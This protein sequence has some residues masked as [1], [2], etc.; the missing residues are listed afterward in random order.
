MATCEDSTTRQIP[1][2]NKYGETVA[3][4]IVDADDYDWLMQ[5]RWSLSACGY[6]SG[7]VRLD[8]KSIVTFMHRYMLRPV[9]GLN[10][11]H[12]NGNRLDNRRCNLRLCTNAENKRNRGSLKNSSSRFVGVSW[13][14]VRRKWTATVHVKLKQ[15]YTECF[16]S[17]EEAARARDRKALEI[18]GEF[19]RLNFPEDCKQ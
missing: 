7:R 8:G 13:S 4:A 3:V 5:S 1:L 10:V 18:Q 16:D 6:A 9:K 14:S 19:A 15:V 11:D 12:I 17:E 2:R